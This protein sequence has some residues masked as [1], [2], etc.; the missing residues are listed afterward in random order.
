MRISAADIGVWVGALPVTFLRAGTEQ[1]KFA[2]KII[3]SLLALAALSTACHESPSDKL[4]D[5]N[6]T[7]ARGDVL[8]AYSNTL[9]AQAKQEQEADQQRSNALDAASGNV[10]A[11]TRQR[12]AIVANDTAAIR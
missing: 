10:A 9:D 6:A 4:A 1:R 11:T 2:M 12:D 3:L 8:N 5:Q 7:N